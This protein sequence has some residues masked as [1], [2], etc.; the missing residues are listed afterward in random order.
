MSQ[1][2]TERTPGQGVMRVKGA[3]ALFGISQATFWRWVKQGKIPRGIRLS[4]RCTVWRRETLEQ[5]LELIL[6]QAATGR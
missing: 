2:I 4:A 3:A 6:E 5:S 1:A